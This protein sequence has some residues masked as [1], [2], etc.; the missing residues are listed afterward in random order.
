MLI[1]SALDGLAVVSSRSSCKTDWGGQK[2]R[3]NELTIMIQIF[4]NNCLFEWLQIFLII[5]FGFIHRDFLFIIN[6]LQ[7]KK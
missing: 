2:F 3:K 1:S 6:K 7:R 5:G 4:I